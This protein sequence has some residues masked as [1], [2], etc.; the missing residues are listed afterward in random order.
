MPRAQT[1][2]LSAIV[3]IGEGLG[4]NEFETFIEPQLAEHGLDVTNLSA[5]PINPNKT[6]VVISIV[7]HVQDLDGILETSLRDAAR[8]MCKADSLS[9]PQH[10]IKMTGWCFIQHC[11]EYNPPIYD[12]LGKY[13]DSDSADRI[14]ASIVPRNMYDASL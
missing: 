4:I 8:N 7:G 3:K 9:S 6:S 5:I 12:V 11:I 1:D 10:I 14:Y 2:Y 13:E